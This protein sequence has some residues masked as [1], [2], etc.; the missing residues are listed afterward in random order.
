MKTRW[1]YKIE[2]VRPPVFAR[3]KT[4]ADFI[5]TILNEHGQQ[6]WELVNAPTTPVATELHLYFKRPS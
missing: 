5:A 3:A 6:G 4:K 1:N 2:I